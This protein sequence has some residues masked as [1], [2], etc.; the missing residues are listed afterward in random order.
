[1]SHHT[2]HA[3][4]AQGI[5][6]RQL[7]QTAAGGALAVTGAAALSLPKA[8]SAQDLTEVTLALD[9]YPNA[10]H[11]GIYMALDRGYFREVGLDVEVFTPA[12]PTTVL[13][14][15]GAGRDTFGISYQN[16]VLQARAQGV[17]VVSVA[18]LVQHPLNSLMVLEESGIESP[19]D[20]EG[21]TIAMAGLPS[22]EAYIETILQSVG[23]SIDDV[24]VVNV[25]YDLMPAVLSGR[26]DAV[27]GVYWT[28]E[29]ILAEQEGHPVRYFR[30][31]EYGVPD[32][33]ELVLVTG[34]QTIAEQ[35]EVVRSM[36]GALRKGY[37]AAMRAPEE[38]LQLLLAASPDLDEEV[39]REGL[40]LLMPLWTD[41]GNVAFGTQTTERWESY[42]S[43]AVDQGF[44]AKGVDPQEAFRNDLFPPDDSATPEASP[45]S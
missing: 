15:V 37:N 26:A 7:V 3:L 45:V 29:T 42:A 23:L 22:D 44:L 20:L 14:T 31:E 25:G 34:E 12:D 41:N 19:A 6:R 9:W 13:Q 28:H 16:D 17:P 10:N 2:Y 38:A 8:S 5:S 1:M 40:E 43:W 30:I 21:K 18:A 24:E 33:Y 39:E 4:A 11:A 36:L 32:Y 27:I 35:E